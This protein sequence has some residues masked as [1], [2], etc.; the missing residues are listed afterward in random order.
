ML[1]DKTKEEQEKIRRNDK[2]LAEILNEVE[3]EF[4]FE[5]LPKIKEEG[6]LK[7]IRLKPTDTKLILQV[8]KGY[9]PLIGEAVLKRLNQ[10]ADTMGLVAEVA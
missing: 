1:A 8:D 5:I 3:E 9:Q 10:L 2:E 4:L 7:N 6:V